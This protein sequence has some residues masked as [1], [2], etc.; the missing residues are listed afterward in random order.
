MYGLG[1]LNVASFQK[2]TKFFCETWLK[3]DKLWN[4]IPKGFGVIGR[5]TWGEIIIFAK[6]MKRRNAERKEIYAAA[7]VLFLDFMWRLYTRDYLNIQR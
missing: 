2:Y 6:R 4:E 3:S 7:R 5:K 1:K